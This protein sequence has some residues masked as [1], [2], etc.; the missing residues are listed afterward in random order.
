MILFKSQ[1]N[2]SRTLFHDNP[3][4]KDYSAQPVPST[5]VQ[6]YSR[7]SGCDTHGKATFLVNSLL[8]N[9]EVHVRGPTI[10]SVSKVINLDQLGNTIEVTLVVERSD[11]AYL[12]VVVRDNNGIINDAL[13]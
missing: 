4:Q 13:V 8:R 3:I 5:P 9:Y 11:V 10:K 6:M 1:V 7:R 12:D 2:E